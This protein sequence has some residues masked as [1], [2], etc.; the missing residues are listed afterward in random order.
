MGVINPIQIVS[1]KTA[2]RI[3]NW[4]IIYILYTVC[5][6]HESIAKVITTNVVRFKSN[7]NKGS[8]IRR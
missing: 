7:K 4:E 2:F 3:R 8:K 1:F 5:A 6:V